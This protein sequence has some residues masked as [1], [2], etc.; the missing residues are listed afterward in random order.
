[1]YECIFCFLRSGFVHL[2]ECFVYVLQG[3]AP[4]EAERYMMKAKDIIE[5]L[6]ACAMDLRD[7]GQPNDN[8]VRT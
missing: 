5:Q 3:S 2:P 1:M 8:V 7:L 6:K 4:N